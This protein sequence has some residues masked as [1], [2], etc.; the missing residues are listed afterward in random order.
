MALSTQQLVPCALIPCG[1]L[2]KKLSA[3]PTLLALNDVHR[4]SGIV[5]SQAALQ[6][7]KATFFFQLVRQ[8]VPRCRQE[9]EDRSSVMLTSEQERE[10]EKVNAFYLQKEAE[11]GG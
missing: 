1:Q 2:I 8:D 11:V 3:T 4:P 5:D 9:S 6:A 7:N 10:L